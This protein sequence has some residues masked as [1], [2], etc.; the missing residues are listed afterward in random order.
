MA[1]HNKNNIF[2]WLKMSL[3]KPTFQL[4]TAIMSKGDE[5]Q[6]ARI[7]DRFICPNCQMRRGE[8]YAHIVPDSDGGPYVADNL[9]FLCVE[10][11]NNLEP[12]RA[13][14]EQKNQLVELARKIKKAPRRDGFLTSNFTLVAGT[15]PTIKLGGGMIITNSTAI[16]EKQNEPNNPYLKLE[17]DEIGRLIISAKFEDTDG[18]VIMEIDKNILHLHTKDAWD[19]VMKRRSIIFEDAKRSINLQISQAEDLSL[20]VIGKLYINGGLYTIDSEQLTSSSGIVIKNSYSI[21]NGYGVLLSPDRMI[22]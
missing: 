12:A 22:F 18:R 8:Q 4:Y 2:T 10:C 1:I 20:L 9:L 6:K 3:S 7:R 19:I 16:L 21:F 17:S 5:Q 13:K 15:H 11:H 14:A